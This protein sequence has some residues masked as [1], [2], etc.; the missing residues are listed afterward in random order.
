MDD[1]MQG[2]ELCSNDPTSQNRDVA[3]PTLLSMGYLQ[4]TNRQG[5]AMHKFDRLGIL[6][7]VTVLSAKVMAQLV[8]VGPPDPNYCN[9]VE[10]L[11][12]NLQVKVVAHITGSVIDGSGAPFKLSLVELRRYISANRQVSVRTVTT[13]EHGQF[14]LAEV[15]QGQYRLLAS[16]ARLFQQPQKLTCTKK[17]CKLALELRVTP[18]DQP[19]SFCPVR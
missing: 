14:D 6:L 13:N 18:T 1:W 4:R 9:K 3:H 8:R 15:E 10:R 17:E 2:F 11:V 19:A 16:P 5:M 12:P 7:L